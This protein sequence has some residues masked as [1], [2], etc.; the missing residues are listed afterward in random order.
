MGRV[1]GISA[2]ERDAVQQHW[3]GG[4]HQSFTLDVMANELWQLRD[5]IS[6]L[7]RRRGEE[8]IT[9]HEWFQIQSVEDDYYVC[10]VWDVE[11]ETAGDSDVNVARN[12]KTRA[13]IASEVIDGLTYTYSYASPV[14]RTSTEGANIEDQVIVPRILED[15]II[16]AV[17]ISS[18]VTVDDE[19]VYW[20]DLNI[21]ARAWAA[22]E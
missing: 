14:Q 16:L 12:P 19:V 4:N 8:I 18:G 20:Q 7:K 21:D 10:R 22:E 11:A 5:A 6:R 15:D 17:A 2:R 1:K 3:K 13:S 9:N